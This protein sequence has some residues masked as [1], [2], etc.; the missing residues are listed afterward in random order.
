MLTGHARRV[1]GKRVAG[2]DLDEV[3]H[4]EHLQHAQHIEG[5]MIGVLGEDDDTQAEMPGVLGV[6]FR[7]P[8]PGGD[9]L[10]E[11]VL[12][13]VDLSDELDLAAQ[14]R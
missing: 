8:A 14:T 12:E 9:C 6:V 5:R 2:V 11:D 7:P 13:L 10:A 1:V 4:D 3:V